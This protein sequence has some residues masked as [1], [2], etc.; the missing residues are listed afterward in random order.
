MEENNELPKEMYTRYR[1]VMAIVAGLLM[2]TSFISLSTFSILSDN[3]AKTFKISSTTLTVL[4]ID[5]F[6]IGLFVAFFL[7]HTGLFDTKIKTGI[8]LSQIFLIVPQFII[9]VSFNLYLLVALRFFQGLMIMILALFSLQLSG[10]FRPEERAISL[11]FTLGAMT[12]GTAAGAFLPGL[13]SGFPWQESYYITGFV[14]VAGAI[15]YFAFARDAPELKKSLIENKKKK[16]HVSPWKN[17]MTWVMGIMQLPV[18]WTLFSIGTF[19]PLYETHLGYSAVL[20][21]DG[22]IIWGVTGF[23]AAFIGAI[24]GDKLSKGRKANREIFNSRLKIMTAGEALMGIGSL[25]LLFVGGISFY[26]IAIALI[27]NSFLQM[28][29]PNYWALPRNVFPI[30]LIGAGAFG[31]GLI[32]NSA[33]AIGP[34]VASVL[35]SHWSLVF[36]IMIAMALFGVVFNMVV[37]KT[38]IASL[39]SMMEEETPE[40]VNDDGIIE[41]SDM[42]E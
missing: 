1:W 17:S 32:S 35:T 25:L 41:E 30:Y 28:F 23:I 6:S 31:M 39:D 37:M 42:E 36:G 4:G 7:G 21:G 22:V 11:A 5:S 27:F 12:L 40:I 3:I 16:H 29:T 2:T 13:L 15:V 19:L 26:L 33:D 10:W 14:M 24:I 18:T 8:L 9:P 20:A 38:K 34:L